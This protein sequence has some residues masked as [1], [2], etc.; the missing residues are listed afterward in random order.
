MNKK[1][2]FLFLEFFVDTHDKT[3][4]IQ[5]AYFTQVVILI[6]SLLLTILLKSIGFSS[7]FAHHNIAYGLIA[8]LLGAIS[9]VASNYLEKDDITTKQLKNC[10]IIIAVTFLFLLASQGFVML[11]LMTFFVF[12]ANMALAAYVMDF[13]VKGKYILGFLAVLFICYVIYRLVYYG[14][15]WSVNTIIHFFLLIIIVLVQLRTII[16]MRIITKVASDFTS[17]E[18]QSEPYSVRLIIGAIKK[19]PLKAGAMYGFI[20]FFSIAEVIS[21]LADGASD[22]PISNKK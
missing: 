4:A 9:A 5:S 17:K 6:S 2:Y 12:F 19:D 15:D 11:I 13:D 22:G 20:H 8:I 10:I 14:W 16:Y 18:L 3:T 1:W 7:Y 21:V